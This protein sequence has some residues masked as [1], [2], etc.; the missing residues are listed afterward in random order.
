M[1]MLKVPA[2]RESG[3]GWGPFSCRCKRF[4]LSEL[5]TQRVGSVQEEPALTQ[6]SGTRSTAM[7]LCSTVTQLC[8]TPHTQQ[9]CS[10]H[11]RMDQNDAALRSKHHTRLSASNLLVDTSNRSG[12]SHSSQ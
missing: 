12:I 10:L 7:A 4:K 6:P 1:A 9:L 11:L 2:F 8:G 3:L 5:D